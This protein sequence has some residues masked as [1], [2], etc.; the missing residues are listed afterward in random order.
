MKLTST[1]KTIGTTYEFTHRFYIYMYKYYIFI[2]LLDWYKEVFTYK[3]SNL[4]QHW[5]Q[6][7]T[8]RKNISQKISVQCAAEVT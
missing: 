3:M 1:M 4:F 6:Y 2:D 7:M 8:Y 5:N